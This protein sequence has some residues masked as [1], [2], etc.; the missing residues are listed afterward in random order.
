[1]GLW[2]LLEVALAAPVELTHQG[3]LVDALGSPVSG[4]HDLRVSLHTAD[5]GGTEVHAETFL[6]HPL[7]GGYYAVR[8]GASPSNVLDSTELDG[9]RWV[10]VQVGTTVLGPRQKLADVPGASGG[11]VTAAKAWT[12]VGP[13][14]TSVPGV[15]L[16]PSVSSYQTAAQVMRFSGWSVRPATLATIPLLAAGEVT[17]SARYK[18]EIE[19]VNQ[20]VTGDCDP[21]FRVTDGQG[22]WCR[23]LHGDGNAFFYYSQSVPAENFFNTFTSNTNR[24]TRFEVFPFGGT[25]PTLIL[26]DSPTSDGLARWSCPNALDPSTGL[27]LEFMGDHTDEI[28]DVTSI[29]VRFAPYDQF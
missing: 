18:L 19:I 15:T 5:T 24:R 23:F 7:D 16:A 11:A 2:T 14:W 4:S 26:G 9:D 21:G 12:L 17:S 27:T 29:R 28:Y 10:E 3:R 13:W 1:M 22:D 20:C 25:T 8:L 6:A